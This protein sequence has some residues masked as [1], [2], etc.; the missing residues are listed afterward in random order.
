[1]TGG[2]RPV[3]KSPSSLRPPPKVEHPAANGRATLVCP[4]DGH[5]A[6]GGRLRL[7]VFI[8]ETAGGVR[9]EPPGPHGSASGPPPR[10][11]RGCIGAAMYAHSP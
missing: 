1:M 11:E 3:T 7:R 9:S 5:N 8:G 10:T 6:A 4:P 2:E